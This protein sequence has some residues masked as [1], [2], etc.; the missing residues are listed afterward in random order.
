MRVL[1]LSELDEVSGG[2]GRKR[3]H[4]GGKRWG[5]G[6]GKNSGKNSGECS[7]KG[8]GKDSGKG[9]GKACTPPP[10]GT[11]EVP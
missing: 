2:S 6:S 1:E 4:C 10:A 3:T 5:K 9:S 8:S 11:P 7:S